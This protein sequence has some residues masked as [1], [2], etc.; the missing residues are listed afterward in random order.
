MI[1]IDSQLIAQPNTL[2]MAK[3]AFNNA[4]FAIMHTEYS[5]HCDL[6]ILT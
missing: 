1:R 4:R 6:K 2:T 3:R 5:L